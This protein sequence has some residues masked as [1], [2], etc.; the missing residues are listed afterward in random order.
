MSPDAHA[1]GF[2]ATTV[3]PLRYDGQPNDP[4]EVVGIVCSLVP[5][6]ARVL[7][8]GCGTGSVSEHVVHTRRAS[9]VGIE[10]DQARAKRARE[11]G[12]TVHAAFPTEELLDTLGKFD[13]VLLADVLEHLADPFSLVTLARRAL[14]AG[15]RVIASVPNVAHWSV[16]YDLARGRFEYRDSGIMDA[17]HLRWFT[18]A[19]A[20]LLFERAGF[21]V[22]SI[23]PTAGYELQ[24]Y[25]E[26]WPWRRFSMSARRRLVRGALRRW[27]RLFACQWVVEATP[28]NAAGLA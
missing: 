9:L 26:R 21:T 20:R 5:F 13:V 15:G 18:E 10:P 17:T 8:I 7:D 25:W 6:E 27:P 11:R 19:G 16:R 3:D 1:S 22:E 4:D 28:R 2:V 12:L 24:V 14:D 23:Q